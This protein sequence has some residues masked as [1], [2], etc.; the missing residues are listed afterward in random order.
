MFPMRSKFKK[1]QGKKKVRPKPDRM[2]LPWSTYQRNVFADM[3]E[4][5][6][7]TIVMAGPGSG[8]TRTILE[9]LYHIPIEFYGSILF[10]AFNAAITEELA[11]QVPNGVTAATHHAL[12]FRAIRRYWGPVYNIGAFGS[13]DKRNDSMFALATKLVGDKP[14]QERLRQMLVYATD[15]CKI[16]LADT[17]EQVSD[18]IN[19]YGVDL[20]GMRWEDFTMLTSSMLEAC[21][22]APRI[23]NGRNVVSF[24]DMIWLPHVHGWPLDQFNRIVVDEGQDLSP[25][26]TELLLS[27]LAPGGRMTIVGDPNQAIYGFAG[28]MADSLKKLQIDL[29]AKTLPLSVSYRCAK[30]IIALAQEVNPMIEAAENAP[31]GKIRHIDAEH[32]YNYVESGTAVLSRTNFPLIRACMAMLNMGLN[33]NIQGRDIGDRFLW[34]IEC[35]QP[36]DVRSLVKSVREWKTDVCDRLAAKKN[37]RTIESISDEAA[38]IEQFCEKAPNIDFVRNKIKTFFADEDAQIK[39]STAHKAKGLEWNKVVMLDKTFHPERGG[40]ETNVWYVSVT[41]ARNHLT[42]AEGKL[43]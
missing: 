18:V 4:G 38:S 8:K 13:V 27:S 43:P 20:C 29:D 7:N 21:R 23:L 25:A 33:A 35:W 17:P 3:A 16:T 22:N 6:W 40:E 26:R 37:W 30:R 31:E 34:R 5:D 28:A 32:L 42:F 19:E 11:R 10:T 15:M 14:T 1:F 41:R 24:A 39:L 12:G 2:I 9:G 36:E